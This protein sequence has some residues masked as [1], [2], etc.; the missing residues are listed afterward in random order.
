MS[1]VTKSEN[2][3]SAE[4]KRELLAKLLNRMIKKGTL[5]IVDAEGKTHVFSGTPAQPGVT[6][7][8]HDRAL[9]HRLFFNPTL[10]AGEAY[11]DGTLT[12]EDGDLHDFLTICCLNIGWGMPDVEHRNTARADTICA[13]IILSRSLVI[14]IRNGFFRAG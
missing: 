7:R 8:L 13:I 2:E 5:T 1:D 9:H 4:Q 10:A 6:V 14:L 3:L 11:M 12:V